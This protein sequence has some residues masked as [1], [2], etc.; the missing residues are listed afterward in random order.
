MNIFKNCLSIAIIL[1][2]SLGLNAQSWKK[3]LPQRNISEL[4]LF[5]YQKAF[6]DYW[7]PYNVVNGFYIDQN[8]KK[9]KA[10]GW[11]QFKRWEWFW[12]QR[13]D[14]VTGQF[15]QF[16]AMDMQFQYYNPPQGLPSGLNTASWTSSGPVSSTGGYAGVG[17]LN[18]IAFHP[19][20]NN[21]FWVGAASGGI[22]KTTNAGSSWTVLNNGTGVLG[23]SDIIV[24]S[25]YSSSN[26]LYIATG[27]KDHWDN[28]SIGVLKSTDGGST[29]NATGLSYTESQGKMVNSLLIDPTNDLIL[30]AAT[31]DGVYKTIN[32]GTNWNTQLTSVNFI[33][34]EY[35]PGD[36]NTLYGS[37]TAGDIYVSTNG[38]TSWTQT[39]DVTGGYRIELGVSP[40][41][42]DWVYAVVENSDSGLFG[43]YKSTDS[44]ASFSLVFDG[45][46]K[47]MLGWESS[48]S[49]T[50]G[51]GWYD[52]SLAVS[53]TQANTVL[54]GGVN[55]WRST[56]GGLNWSIVNHWWGDGVPAVH[57]DKHKLVFRSDG[58]LFE[59]NDGGIYTS[60]NNGTSWTDKTNGMVISQMYK[61]GVSQTLNNEVITGLQDNGTKLKSGAVWSDVKGGDGM[62]CL[63][64]Y[65]D[66]NIQYGTYV[67]GQ[68]DRTI[69]HWVTA[70]DISANISGDH[71]GAWVT[72]YIIDPVSPSTLYA[73]YSDVWKTTDR[74]N[75]WTKIST[76]NFPGKI[77]AMAIAPSNN[78][79]LYVSDPYTIWK[80]TDGG[81]N[82]SNIT[83]GLP[84][85]W[86]TYIAVKNDDPNTV[87]VT[88]STYS[89]ASVYQTTNGGTNWTNISTGLPSVPT[90]CIIH[91]K[92]ITSQTNLYAGTD[93]GVYYK[94]GTANWVQFNTGIPNVIVTELDIYYDN[95]TPQNS[96][97]HAASY[98][99]GL[100]ATPIM[101]DI[102]EETCADLII[103]EYLEGSSNNKYLEFYN[104][105][106]EEI[107]LTGNYSIKIY[108]NGSTTATTTINLTGTIA[109][110][111]TF[112]LAHTSAV[113]AV[114]PN[115]T[116]GSCNFN[117][118]DAIELV[119]GSTTLDIFGQI[120]F[121]PG[122]E[123]GTGL[124]STADNTLVRKPEITSGDANGS[125]VFDPG[126]E[127]LGFAQNYIDSLGSHT[128]T[129]GLCEACCPVLSSTPANVDI[130][131]STCQSGCTLGG[132]TI[133]APTGTP[134]PTG[135]TLYYSIDGGSWSTTVPVYDQDGPSQSI[136][137][138]CQCD[139]DAL[140]FSPASTAVST[141]PGT[142]P[143]PETPSITIIDNEC[144][145]TE[146]SIYSEGCG[147]GTI[148]EWAL[149][150]AG[151]WSE[152]A[153]A[154]STEPITVYARCMDVESNCTSP[155]VSA[156][157]D[158]VNCQGGDPTIS[159]SGGPTIADPC[160]CAGNGLFDEE[161]VVTSFTGETWT[162]S[163][164][165][166]FLNPV[167]FS[168]FPIATP[169]VETTA[170]SGIYTLV[171]VHLDDVGY[172]LSV[173]NGTTTLSISNECWYPDPT[174]T[175]LN[176]SYCE[177]SPS[178][179]LTGSA[180]LGDGS[181]TATA[182]TQSFT[183]NGNSATVFDPAALGDGVYEVIYFFD[184]ADDNP[185]NKHPGCTAFDTLDVTV[186]VVPTVNDPANQEV[187]AGKLTSAV[188]FN[189][190][191]PTGVTYTWTNNNANIGL[192]ANGTGN[193]SAFTAMNT[194]S[195]TIIATIT[196]TPSTT[197]CT[198][199]P[200]T[201][202]ITVNPKPLEPI[203]SNITVC[204]GGST[205]IQPQ[206]TGGGSGGSCPA[207][208]DMLITGVIDGPLTGGIPKAVEFYVI[209]DIPDLSLYGFG[210]ANNGGGTDGQ[211]YT[212]PAVFAAAGTRIWV[213]TEITAFTA[214][215]GFPPTYVNGNAPNI[216]G[217]DAIELFFNGT[218]IDVFGDINASGTSTPW[219]YMDGWVYRKNNTGN[220][221]STFILTNWIY[222]GINAVDG[223][224]T[225]ASMPIPMPVGTY[226]CNLGTGGQALFNFY[227]DAALTNLLAGPVAS[228]DPHTTPLNS[229]QTIWVTQVDI[230]TGCESNA[231]PVVVTVFA[232]ATA[233]AGD[234]KFFCGL[235]TSIPLSATSNYNG[236]WSS[237]GAGT[238]V[239]PTSKNTTYN[240]NPADLGKTVKFKWT[241]LAPPNSGCPNAIDSVG[242]T[243]VPPTESAEFSY[244]QDEYCPGS[245]NP[246][247]THATGI[248]GVYTYVV[249]SDG[250]NL[251]LDKKTGEININ[252]SDW[253]TY[254]VTNTVD[255]R[256]NLIIT[257]VVD[258]PIS[259]GLPK[260]IE[261][262]AVKAISDLSRYSL[263]SANN[264]NGSVGPEYTFPPDAVAAG[265]HIWVAS[266]ADQ[267]IN[268]F[269]FGPTYVNGNVPNINGDDAIVLY[270]DG[271]RI[272]VFGDVNESGTGTLWEYMD[273]WAYRKNNTS[274]DGTVF[275]INNWIFSGP[276]ALDFATSNSTAL[277]P[278]PIG[279]F[280]TNL[281]GGCNA[282]SHTEM[283]IIGDLKLPIVNCPPNQG[284][285]LDPG[286]C[287]A[288]LWYDDPEVSDNC[289]GEPV[290]TK[291]SGPDKGSEFTLLG[292]PYTIVYEV[293]DANGNGPVTCS[294]QIAIYGY[295]NPIIGTLACNDTVQVSLD[296]NCEIQLN[297]DM[298]LEGGPYQCYNMFQLYVNSPA[299][300]GINI[301]NLPI[302]LAPGAYTITV[303][304]AA[305]TKN[306]CS[307]TII[308][309]DKLAPQLDCNCPV[310]GDL[311]NGGYSI[312][313]TYDGCYDGSVNY[314]L[315]KPDVIENCSYTLEIIKSEIVPGTA[316][317]TQL[318][319]NT[320]KVTD[321]GG[322][323]DICT[324]EYL[325]KGFDIT[326]LKWPKN[327]DNLPANKK[328]L[329]CDS[330][331][332]IDANGNPDP[333]YTGYPEGIGTCQ[334]AEVFYSDEVHAL[335]CGTKILRK[336]DLVDDCTGLVYKHTQVIRITDSKA[337]TFCQPQTF[338]V[339]SKAYIC[340]GD[341]EIPE[342]NCLEDNCCTDVR[343][344]ITTNMNFPVTGDING[345]GFVD[346]NETWKLLNV[347][348]G[349]YELCYHAV[350]CCE[351]VATY[352]ILFEVYD[353]N[354]PIAIC[355]QFKQVS[356]TVSADARVAATDFN[357]G[358]FD[359]CKPVYF[360][361][362]RVNNNNEYDGGCPGLNGD[363]N[364][365]TATVDVWYDELVYFCCDDA[366]HQVMV[367]LRVFEVD[368]GPGPVDPKRYLFGGDLYGHYN[369]CW[370]MVTIECKIPPALTCPPVEITCEESLDPNDNPKLWPQVTSI[371]G[372]DLSYTDSRD[373]NVCSA[374]ITR[375]WTA[376]SCT[377]STQCKQS[378]KVVQTTPF[379]PCTIVFPSDKQVHCT[380]D[381][382]DGGT[383][384]WDEY[385]CNVV[386][387]EIIREDT[388]KFVE[389]A[390]YKIL[391]EWAVIDWCVYKAN[392]GAEDNLDQVTSARKLN[393]NTLVKDGYYR[394]TQ[395]LKVVDL[396]PPKITTEDACVGFT[397]GC[398]ANGVTMTAF[399]SDTCNTNEEYWW[400]YK[401]EDLDC[402][403]EPIQVSY[404]YYPK[405]PTALVG[406]R[407]LDKL[408]KVKEAKLVMLS[409][410][411]EGHY[412]VTWTVGDGCGNATTAEQVFT[413]V[414][415]KAPTPI[416]VNLATATMM[417]CMVEICAIMFD[418]GGCNGNCIS[419][420]DNCTPQSELYF[421][422]GPVL[423][424]LY[425]D[426]VKWQNQYN[427]YG[428]YFYDPVTG[429]ISTEEKYLFGEAYSW[430]PV[431]K[432][433]CRIIGIDRLGNGPDL[434]Q[435][436][437]VY[438]WDKFALNEECDDN[439]YDFG[440]VILSINTE[441]DDCPNVG[442][443]VS[444]N[445]KTCNNE[446]GINNVT[447]SFDDGDETRVAL[448]SENGKFG[449]RLSENN[450]NVS[451]SKKID[452]IPGLTTLDLVIIQKH[453]LGMKTANDMCKMAAMDIN[454]DGKVS[455]SDIL[456]GRKMLLGYMDAK[457]S[458]NFLSDNFI[459]EN[460]GNPDI[461]LKDAYKMN[462]DVVEGKTVDYVDFSGVLAGD[463]NYSAG[464]IEGRSGNKVDMI[465]DELELIKGEAY[466]IPV[467]LSGAE[468]VSGTQFEMKF[469]G[470]EVE[471]VSSKVIDINNSNYKVSDN[472]L[473]FSWN[474]PSDLN[475]GTDEPVMIISVIAKENGH[476]A[477]SIEFSN[478]I[479]APEIYSNDEVSGLELKF[480]N[481]VGSFALHQ[482]IPNPFSDKTV[483]GFDLPVDN[484]YTL[485]IY[486][487]TGKTVKEISNSGKAGYNS[488][489]ISRKEIGGNGVFYYRL[490]SGD[491]TDTRKMILIE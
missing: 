82:W 401:V 199:T 287:S 456:Y 45:A 416:L 113:L 215:F 441:D 381:L 309:M 463:V 243:T 129:A 106:C 87:W 447:V 295:P 433:S 107:N 290:V 364:P 120:G 477:N 89:G 310:G 168:P 327:Y 259:G 279:T 62:E 146:G 16:D 340:N 163:A 84:G 412:K 385:P 38:G 349:I 212:F 311:Q 225:N 58:N 418:K 230:V 44:G 345:N 80:T 373:N 69:D 275:N 184:A 342:I 312:E 324:Q 196:V 104:P 17:R 141:V 19:S 249:V 351:N 479:L 380:N 175:G 429:A 440:V 339:P 266:E 98:G 222:S 128:I 466:E 386:T 460:N 22:W 347:P 185:N 299:Y 472:S 135:S 403:C 450:Y 217:D 438:V 59:C 164:N 36:F 210:S 235:P 273:G 344:W 258:G 182:E 79:V 166:G 159:N 179:T 323:T 76:M 291:I 329:E 365:K 316:C 269:G 245:S 46:T 428:K 467:Y 18:C 64:D 234:N 28:R 425:V 134:C 354:P 226:I 227:S 43:I 88:L 77:R 242:L 85:N 119:K 220:D 272:D 306:K 10:A 186:Y 187:C 296:K 205:L 117:G 321:L 195:A 132:G 75:T 415:K 52:L 366:G 61:L 83:A 459:L 481:V 177:N 265:T 192:G 105:T 81:S 474:N 72:P 404:N 246:T 11:K 326:A 402:V 276:N 439:N 171:G 355:E 232:K 39:L 411:K 126:I 102:P 436:L 200:Q 57:A 74:G 482:N 27:D 268:F 338:R 255:G 435:V 384:T 239:S 188:L 297:A 32:G 319:R 6:N 95:A 464:I 9:T 167:T 454:S 267:F 434:T 270:N 489:N 173:T 154:Y 233:E 3:N 78:Q 147:D 348:K 241:T 398:F 144:P 157:T 333:S 288:F 122:T 161:V 93:N 274:N 468:N 170:G 23:V 136:T 213:A 112:I 367:S 263:E 26:T 94:A 14:P 480:R 271:Q 90:N 31:N 471:S 221:G 4:T 465:F 71:V 203:V 370:S 280:T 198:G 54:I 283:I 397:D 33:D 320:W 470:M 209:N 35:K 48:G 343:W 114:T 216:N 407:S 124:V 350:D 300:N 301:T 360:K 190:T 448:T 41:Q 357:S 372:V 47:N 218:V 116:S 423:P 485:S 375:T 444:G 130:T 487:I 56:D 108:Y 20:D 335:D 224:T 211:E 410:L 356:L 305:N 315:P 118:D 330:G 353:G 405:P 451:A 286:D 204:E 1:I 152:A 488:V 156:T 240:T 50:G 409:S 53:N 125:D 260:A 278:W 96:V 445:V 155:V 231:V 475:I 219:E 153:P 63:I 387:S 8:G 131:N 368:P 346:K 238:I 431:R 478:S 189:G 337:P 308:V 150:E 193:I 162:V 313:C 214:F 446:T 294:F 151:P 293:Y 137:T 304:D 413:V 252:T 453:I 484:E 2:L 110:E 430:D 40:N 406:K 461:S 359:N 103:S 251:A 91:N 391:R 292:S 383:P 371:C 443:L 70:T 145:S 142:C 158:P 307:T 208:E 378:I 285:Y 149:S 396:I 127:W 408:D 65:T 420:F 115:Q 289:P 314:N 332:P 148:L 206:S 68:I 202:T 379:D 100:W 376:S 257:G 24:P 284:V 51:Q 358:S 99:R 377:K 201:F 160:T 393:C 207:T 318:L 449:I 138:R 317:G 121:D 455:A 394:Y 369:D 66:A 437:E 264:G 194:T 389:G 49:D 458:Y 486:D 111:G 250:P 7:N 334:F 42:P 476:L 322:N 426:E 422:F 336:W 97:L 228:Y 491:N 237:D 15:P 256:G 191:P 236:Q 390:C 143:V 60:S 261:L 281:T 341:V 92:L 469:R 169:L 400:K 452:G 362:L 462:I 180:Q 30:L 254:N 34:M 361:V 25:D 277:K 178:V 302:E 473:K 421:T 328:M 325:F 457:S 140:I 247:V 181:G 123:W 86:I 133:T 442:S 223:Y 419:S 67:N 392:T 5:D 73:G 13:V 139:T 197:F 399:A 253:G 262:Y 244:I 282:N 417:N 414:D 55:T 303:A 109:S 101:E 382:P 176:T 331:Y 427:K 12:D 248:N 172:I 352:C 165:S 432:T 183:I 490:K 424:K 483:I 174:I 395:V 229:P 29:W 37:T 298:L 21:T 363:D 388:F 374:N